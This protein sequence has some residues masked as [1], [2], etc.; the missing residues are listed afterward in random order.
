MSRSK[1][2][3]VV[4]GQYT[5]CGLRVRPKLKTT[6]NP[7][8]ASCTGCRRRVRRM[9]PKDPGDNRKITAAVSEGEPDWGGK[10]ENCGQSPIV[11]GTSL[12]GPCCFGEAETA[13]GNW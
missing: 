3:L 2:H 5:V 6:A 4:G 8:H 9:N 10:C 1:R 13:G 7:E 11:A 12:C